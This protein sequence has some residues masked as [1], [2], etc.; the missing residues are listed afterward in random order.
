[1]GPETILSLTVL[2]SPK[3]EYDVKNQYILH[4]TPQSEVNPQGGFRVLRA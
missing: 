3:L 2:E 4:K 1:M